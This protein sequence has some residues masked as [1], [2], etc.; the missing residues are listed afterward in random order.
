MKKLALTLSILAISVMGCADSDATPADSPARSGAAI[1]VKGIGYD[2][3]SVTVDVG[4]EVTWTNEDPVAHSVTTGVP[5]K[6][7]VP[8]VTADKPPKPDGMIDGELEAD[9]GTFTFTFDEA[10]TYKYFCRFHAGMKAV[11]IVE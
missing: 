3:G 1:A 11:V 9:Q 6:Q 10:G 2:P 4:E 8:G 7:G 5:Q